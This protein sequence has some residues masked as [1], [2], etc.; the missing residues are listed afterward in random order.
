MEEGPFTSSFRHIPFKHPNSTC[1]TTKPPGPVQEDF[2]GFMA[3]G[4]EG[5]QRP[6]ISSSSSL[7]LLLGVSLRPAILPSTPGSATASRGRAGVERCTTPLSMRHTWSV[8]LEARAKGQRA[9]N[10]LLQHAQPGLIDIF[11][12][13]AIF[14]RL[15]VI[16]P[17]PRLM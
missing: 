11:A 14:Y 3:V 13:L 7:P 6:S 9:I 10:P 16:K 15:G 8:I 12:H 2:A 4:E 5:K 1:K 17:P